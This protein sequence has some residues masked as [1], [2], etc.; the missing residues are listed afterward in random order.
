MMNICHNICHNEGCWILQINGIL[1][2]SRYI[3]INCISFI[4]NNIYT[5]GITKTLL[6]LLNNTFIVKV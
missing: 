2:G 3:F 5:N 4:G 6:L 1:S